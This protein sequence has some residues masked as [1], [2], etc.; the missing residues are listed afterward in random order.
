[1]I[2]IGEEPG[3]RDVH[4]TLLCVCMVHS[5]NKQKVPHVVGEKQRAIF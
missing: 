4:K 3:R 1:M 5:N 2:N